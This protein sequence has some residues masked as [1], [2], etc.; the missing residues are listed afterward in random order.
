MDRRGS[1]LQDACRPKLGGCSALGEG[2]VSKSS[3]GCEREWPGTLEPV[4]HC[5]LCGGERSEAEQQN[6]HD[7][8]FGVAPGAWT[9]RRCLACR[10]L[11]LDPRPDR[12]SIHVAYRNYYTHVT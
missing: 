8:T 11:Y 5:P 2:H 9:F 4:R 10:A 1:T 12:A 3:T 7:R 6:L